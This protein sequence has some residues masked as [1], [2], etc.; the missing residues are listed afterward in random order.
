MLTGRPRVSRSVP[1]DTIRHYWTLLDAI[2]LQPALPGMTHL[3]CIAPELLPDRSPGRLPARS[4]LC[5]PLLGY[6]PSFFHI[7]FTPTVLFLIPFQCIS[8][9]LIPISSSFRSIPLFCPF[10]TCVSGLLHVSQ[11]VSNLS[12][13]SPT[14][15]GAT[16]PPYTHGLSPH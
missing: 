11:M 14:S 2:Q 3:P 16:F 7:L 13:I 8:L 12:C 1:F 9:H 5:L 4:R 15:L 6:S 10:P